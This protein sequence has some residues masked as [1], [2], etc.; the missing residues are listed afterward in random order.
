M[1]TIVGI[2]NRL[3]GDD[4]VGLLVVKILAERLPAGT[5]TF[6][7]DGD[8]LQLLELMTKADTMVIVDAVQS[9]AKPGAIFRIDASTDPVPRHFRVFTTHSFDSI[10]TIELARAMGLLP[11]KM[12]IYGIAGKDF[13][14]TETMSC[15]VEESIAIVGNKILREI[16]KINESQRSEIKAT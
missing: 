9:S 5:S 11:K 4:A 14:Y 10:Q 7:L 2:G 16:E 3:R 15:E 13:S 6:G 8:Q 12:I 1:V